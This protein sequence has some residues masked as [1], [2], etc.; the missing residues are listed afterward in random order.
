MPWWTWIVIWVA[1]LALTLLVLV[2][3]GYYLFRKVKA[4]LKE[5][6]HAGEVLD[7]STTPA[8]SLDEVVREPVPLAV[9]RDP[10]DVRD[11]RAAGKALRVA[12]RRERRVHRRVNR[13]QPVSLRDLPHV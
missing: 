8:A 11:E 4:L 5:V 2:A 12:A 1:L 6:E 9:F 3:L 7:R 13:S 10:A